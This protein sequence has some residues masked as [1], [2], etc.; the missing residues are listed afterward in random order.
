VIAVLEPSTG[1]IG[2]GSSARFELASKRII[3]RLQAGEELA[4]VMDDLTGKED[5]RSNEGAMGVLTCGAIPR[6]RAYMDGVIFA[7]A[8]FVSPAQFWDD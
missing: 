2:V 3:A 7:F 1:R 5:V 8:K 4:T 6:D